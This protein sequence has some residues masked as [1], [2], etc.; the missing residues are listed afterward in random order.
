GTEPLQIR[1]IAGQDERR[2]R[3]QRVFVGL[4]R[5]QE[6]EEYRILRIGVGIDAGRLGLG[7]TLDLAGPPLGVGDDL[8][9]LAVG[10]RPNPGGLSFTLA[11]VARGDALAFGAHPV[12][13]AAP[14]LLG[15]AD[16][17]DSEV[18]HSDAVLIPR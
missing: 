12:E 4:Q 18:D 13:H 2:A 11:A 9:P 1:P 7:G 3:A 15:E 16:A 5:S 17:P 8:G 10:L 14:V 6:L